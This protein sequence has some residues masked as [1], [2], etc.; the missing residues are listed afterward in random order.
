MTVFPRGTELRLPLRPRIY[1]D[2]PAASPSSGMQELA[3]ALHLLRATGVHISLF[4]FVFSG[5]GDGYGHLA[6]ACA[7]GRK[8]IV[9]RLPDGGV[10]LMLVNPGRED[11][12]TEACVSAGLEEACLDVGFAGM[13]ETSA[14]HASAADVSDLDEL[15]LHLALR[16]PN[17]LPIEHRRVAA[18]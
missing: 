17:R 18:A 12:A 7:F 14:I 16:V 3:R 1:R 2:G 15:L 13:V 9:G 11:D 4:R 10:V 5:D 6:V 8:G